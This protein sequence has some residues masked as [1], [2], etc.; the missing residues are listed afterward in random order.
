MDGKNTGISVRQDTVYPE[1]WRVHHRDYISDMVNLSRAKD[2]AA[3][4]GHERIDHHAIW[5]AAS[6]AGA[7]PP[8]RPPGLR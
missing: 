3:V 4:M 2:A 5:K 8:V 7:R 1:M 6:N